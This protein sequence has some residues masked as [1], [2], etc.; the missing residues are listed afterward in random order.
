MQRTNELGIRVALGAPRAHIFRIVMASVAVS[1]AIG[2]VAGL[3]ASFGLGHFLA[4]W[5]G[6][7][8]MHP[9]LVTGISLLLLG[10]AAVACVIPARRALAIDPM[11]AL[12]RE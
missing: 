2:V 9:L 12:R 6:V 8:G 10:V 4:S 11:I 3:A 5:A 7:T 1:V